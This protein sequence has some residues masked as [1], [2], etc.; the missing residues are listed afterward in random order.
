MLAVLTA[1]PSRAQESAQPTTAS[2]IVPGMALMPP[3]L[4]ITPEE[5]D[6]RLAKRKDVATFH[7]TFPAQAKPVE[8]SEPKPTHAQDRAAPNQGAPPVVEGSSKKKP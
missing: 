7:P 5:S 2:D 1:A 8:R 6:R 4:P 3:Q